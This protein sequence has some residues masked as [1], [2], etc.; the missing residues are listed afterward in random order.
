[1]PI[2]LLKYLPLVRKHWK[3]ITCGVALVA[4]FFA[5]WNVNGTRWESRMLT[6]RA[7]RQQVV[8]DAV[9][10]REV[11]LREAFTAQQAASDEVARTLDA[12]IATLQADYTELTTRANTEPL[13]K[14]VT[15]ETCT[16]EPNANPFTDNFVDLW[17]DAGGM[18]D[19]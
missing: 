7:E 11:E 4:C 12:T 6:E 1:M 10:Q 9:M 13:V 3:L 14:T 15:V 18:R 16:G 2:F 8:L 5:G 17:N 19:D